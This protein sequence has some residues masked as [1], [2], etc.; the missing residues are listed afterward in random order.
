MISV[1]QLQ[2]LRLQV[3]GINTLLFYI[4]SNRRAGFI[5]RTIVLSVIEWKK[6]LEQENGITSKDWDAHFL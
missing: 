2:V 1:K 3:A 5:F 6:V 4:I